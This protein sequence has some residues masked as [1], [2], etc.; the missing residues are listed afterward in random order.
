MSEAMQVSQQQIDQARNVLKANMQKLGNITEA[1]PKES[2]S[3]HPHFLHNIWDAAGGKIFG[4]Y[5]WVEFHSEWGQ[6]VYATYYQGGIASG[7]AFF[8][9]DYGQY[10]LSF[11]N[12]TEQDDYFARDITKDSMT[13][14]SFDGQRTLKFTLDDSLDS[15]RKV[16]SAKN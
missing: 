12:Y 5:A 13:L 1:A 16:K 9:N 4:K 15:N 11:S 14:V 7:F 6:G 2:L 8:G 3:V 10:T